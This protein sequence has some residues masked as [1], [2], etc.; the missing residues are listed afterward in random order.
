MPTIQD[1]WNNYSTTPTKYTT[2]AGLREIIKRER[3][4]ELAFEGSR[5]WDLRRW[6]DAAYELNQPVRG[7]TISGTTDESYYLVRTI[8]QQRF[9]APRDYLWPIRLSNLSVNPNLTQNPGW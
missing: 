9:I 5:F 6:K 8:F 4:I 7:W 3:A 1:A 2:K